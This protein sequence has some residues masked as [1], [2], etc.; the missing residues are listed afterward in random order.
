M[1]DE[2]KTLDVKEPQV[3]R[4]YPD[5]EAGFFWHH[6]LLLQKCGAGIWIGV[7]PDGDLEKIDLNVTEHIALDRKALFPRAQAPYVYAFDELSRAELEGY[8]RRAKMM[9][10]LFNDASL[11][12]VDAYEWLVADVTRDDFGEKVDESA[13]D[14]GVVLRDSALVE[15]EGEEVYAVRVNSAKKEEWMRSREES[16]GDARLLGHY[17]DGQGRRYLDFSEAIDMMTEAKY[18]DWPLTGPRACLEFLKCVR[19]GTSDLVGYHLQWA[20][21]S[22]VSS[23]AAAVFEHRTLCDCLKN[24]IQID[25]VDP[26]SLLGTEYMVRRIIQ[27]ETA[28]SRNPASPDYSGLEVIME[29]GIGTAGEA[30]AVKFQE[31]VGGRLKDRAQVQKQARLYKEEFGRRRTDSDQPS[32]AQAKSKGK[33]KGKAKARGTE[34][35]ATGSE[36]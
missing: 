36:S 18:E 10:N 3:I 2:T 4:H 23:Y 28:V 12:E 16:K 20:H 17:T 6:R 1:A 8:K 11:E 13:V 32:S 14:D 19:S 29:S 9:V 30:R 31:W 21:N 15:I 27:I 34:N 26:S 25:Q 33:G 22:G 5:D 7:S 35:Q 24:F